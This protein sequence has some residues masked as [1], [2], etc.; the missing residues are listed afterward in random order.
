M[1]ADFLHFVIGGGQLAMLA[2][3]F[4]RLGRLTDHVEQH[5]GRIVQ[6]ERRV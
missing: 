4:Y 5:E 2:G 1:S 6:L 3:I